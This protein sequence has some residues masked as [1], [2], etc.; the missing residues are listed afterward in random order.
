MVGWLRSDGA[1]ETGGRA[2][3]IAIGRPMPGLGCWILA[4]IVLLP[5]LQGIPGRFPGRAG[6]DRSLVRGAPR[7]PLIQEA[8]PGGLLQ[9]TLQPPLDPIAHLLELITQAACFLAHLLPPAPGATQQLL[10]HAGAGQGE[11]VE[12]L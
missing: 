6:R 8:L 12:A 4:R 10:A 7:I 5:I 3:W 9:P 2:R 11:I 1:T